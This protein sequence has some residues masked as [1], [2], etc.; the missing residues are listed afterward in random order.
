MDQT[1]EAIWCLRRFERIEVQI[2]NG[3]WSVRNGIRSPGLKQLYPD[4]DIIE[5]VKDVLFSDDGFGEKSG[6]TIVQVKKHIRFNR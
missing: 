4:E 3:A 5:D 2:Y 1:L 6:V